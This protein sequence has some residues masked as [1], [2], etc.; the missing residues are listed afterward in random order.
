MLKI[1]NLYEGF[2][3]E[4]RE[5]YRHE[6][7]TR[8]GEKM[9]EE[10][11]N[12]VRRLSNAEWLDVKAEGERI[13]KGIAAFMDLD[14]ADREVQALIAEHHRYIEIFYPCSM[15]IY[16]GLATLYVDDQRFTAYYEKYAPGLAQFMNRAMMHFA[17]SEKGAEERGN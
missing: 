11:E 8:Y 10:S 6:A 2:S 15:E 1:E 17:S 14:P 3:P 7:R 16:R 4:T 12:R 13:T 5:A 9:V